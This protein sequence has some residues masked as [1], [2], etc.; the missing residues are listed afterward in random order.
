M[1][2]RDR[3]INHAMNQFGFTKAEAATIYTVFLREKVMKIDKHTGDF[4][5]VHGAFWDKYPM[6]RALEIA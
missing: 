4:K 3:F 2:T 1:S 6:N 5:L